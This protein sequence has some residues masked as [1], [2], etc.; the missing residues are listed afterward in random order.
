MT[1]AIGL[2]RWW[3]RLYTKGLP[4]EMRDA[5]RAEIESDLWEQ[6][7]DATANGS[8]PDE[9]ALE[10]FGRLL[11][12]VPADVTWRLQ[13]GLSTRSDRSIKM[14]ESLTMRGFFLAAVAIAIAPAAFGIA[15]FAGSGEGFHGA[16]R[17]IFGTLQVAAAAT[18]VAGLVLSTRQPG[19][20]IGLVALGAICMVVLWY[21]VPFITVPLGAA[22]VFL[23]YRRARQAGWPRG[24]DT[25]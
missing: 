12:G 25:T 7:E 2:T 21:W 9:T 22:L 18:M 8:Q 14:N 16:E 5:R 1:L 17:A 20:A 6:G 4:P 23:A 3:V 11:L 13:A 15:I 10:V 24:A 19:L